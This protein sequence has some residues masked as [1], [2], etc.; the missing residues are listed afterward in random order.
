MSCIL[1][2]P[3]AGA[4]QLST[5]FKEYVKSY[6]QTQ[7][8]PTQSQF[9]P[10]PTAAYQDYLTQVTTQDQQAH[11]LQPLLAGLQQTI[12]ADQEQLT[13][14]HAQRQAIEQRQGIL[15]GAMTGL[16]KLRM[17]Q[18]GGLPTCSAD[19]PATKECCP[20]PDPQTKQVNMDDVNPGVYCTPERCEVLKPMQTGAWQVQGA[21][22]GSVVVYELNDKCQLTVN[23][24]PGAKAPIDIPCSQFRCTPGGDTTDLIE[25]CDIALDQPTKL[26]FVPTVT[27]SGGTCRPA[28]QS[29]Y[30]AGCPQ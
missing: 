4:A 10:L 22:G 13:A 17:N 1:N 25:T 16:S 18:L 30:F 14:A 27:F 12:S 23:G 24:C 6:L 15:T 3:S 9:S 19:K 8:Y 5:Q 7:K 2:S 29:P 20:A 26:G 28:T 21:V 11:T